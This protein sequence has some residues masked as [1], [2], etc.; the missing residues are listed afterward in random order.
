MAVRWV[1]TWASDRARLAGSGD[2][3]KA[4]VPV[5]GRVTVLG[6]QDEGSLP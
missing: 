3:G 4:A 1:T 5:A 2:K 6:G